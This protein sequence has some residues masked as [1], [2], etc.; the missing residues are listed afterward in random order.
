[1]RKK[2]PNLT[3]NIPNAI[4]DPMHL[5]R[6]VY[7]GAILQCLVFFFNAYVVYHEHWLRA[8]ARVALYGFPLWASGT[9]SIIVGLFLCAYVIKN[10]TTEYIVK[11]ND[12]DNESRIIRLQKPVPLMNL[13][14]YAFLHMDS[15][16]LIS[17]RTTFVGKRNMSGLDGIPND[18]TTD[19][20]LQKENRTAFITLL[21]TVFALSGFILQNLGTRELHFSASIAQLI[22]TLALTVLRSWLRRNVGI[23]PPDCKELYRG[24]ET[25][26]M[27]SEVCGIRR[28][29][30]YARYFTPPSEHGYR[31][32]L[33]IDSSARIFLSDDSYYRNYA[34][35]L[36]QTQVYLKNPDLKPGGDQFLF[37]KA[38]KTIAFL[39]Y[40]GF[41]THVR[42]MIQFCGPTP[43]PFGT[44]QVDSED[45]NIPEGSLVLP[46]SLGQEHV[47]TTCAY[48]A[49]LWSFSSYDFYQERRGETSEFSGSIW[50]FH[51][52]AVCKVADY[53]R[54]F[55][56]LGRYIGPHNFTA[57]QMN[58]ENEDY[59]K[60]F[61]RCGGDLNG[62]PSKNQWPIFG[63]HYLKN[64]RQ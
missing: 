39:N 62:S 48:L 36:L 9:L 23:P 5:W 33:H 52:V 6:C 10:A 42:K 15:Q 7:I 29:T 57:W 51:I 40:L 14:A 47:P 16:V 18:I 2:A 20:F 43:D 49:A 44:N 37:D 31:S 61:A 63:L 8:G 24:F 53:E 26:H 34:R 50:A 46:L 45:L 32:R 12:P 58:S 27:I 35:G 56:L 11:R 59:E 17:Q 19:L 13:P 60:V 4:T 1:M 25:T 38:T 28:F 22:A 64:Y 21:G 41:T 55:E 30:D 3:I 54:R